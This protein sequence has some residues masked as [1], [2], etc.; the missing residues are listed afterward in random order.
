MMWNY[1]YE[2][3]FLELVLVLLIIWEIL[4]LKIEFCLFLVNSLVWEMCVVWYWVR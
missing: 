1:F 4:K 2:L 3:V